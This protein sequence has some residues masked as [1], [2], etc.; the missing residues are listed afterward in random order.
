MHSPK[1][2]ETGKRVDGAKA[3]MELAAREAA[4][5]R[6]RAKDKIRQQQRE[7][8]LRH[9]P[10][11]QKAQAFRDKIKADRLARDPIAQKAQVFRDKIKA[12]RIDREY[13]RIQQRKKRREQ[14][15]QENRQSKDRE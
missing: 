7:A 3:E 12:D 14:R 10:I 15:L 2:V 8:R 11:A 4:A 1:Q 6:V 5:Y 13:R 9:D